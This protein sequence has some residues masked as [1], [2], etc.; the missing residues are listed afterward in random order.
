MKV[1]DLLEAKNHLEQYAEECRET[2]VVVT[3]DGHPAFELTP[4]EVDED[5]DLVNHLIQHNPEFQAFLARQ[6]EENKKSKPISLEEA[7]KRLLG[8]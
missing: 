4:L 5:D 8:E 2:T 3:I 7:R 6:A 1:I